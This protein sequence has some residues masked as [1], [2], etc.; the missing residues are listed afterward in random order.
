MQ[1]GY[2]RSSSR[3]S[4]K[5]FGPAIGPTKFFKFN[6]SGKG[7]PSTNLS[8]HSAFKKLHLQKRATNIT[9]CRR[10][11][12]IPISANC[13][14][15]YVA[16]T[17]S[18]IEIRLIRRNRPWMQIP[19]P[20]RSGGSPNGYPDIHKRPTNRLARSAFLGSMLCESWIFLQVRL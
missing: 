10:A 9:T 3:L 4:L 15:K 12:R 18:T 19:K 6:A 1:T 5:D 17:V 14:N 11:E 8:S 20:D 2:S 7:P 13:T 16:I